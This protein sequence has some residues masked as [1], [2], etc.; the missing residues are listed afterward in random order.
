MKTVLYTAPTIYPVSLS[1]LKDH[2]RVDSGTFAG[3]IDTTQS[4]AP[5]SHVIAD[6]YTTHVGTGV[7]VSGYTA[8]VN[9]ESGTNGATGT[10]DVKIQE[11]DDNVT[12]TDWTGGAFTQVT[13]AN[14]NAIYE[15][16]YTGTKAY[17]RTVAKVLL[18]ACEFGTTVIRKNAQASDDTL[19]T[20]Y[21]YAAIEKAEVFTGRQL[22]TATWDAYLDQFPAEDYIELPFG[23]LQSIT[24]LKYKDSDGT[25]TTMTPTTDYLTETMGE[26][27]GR[28]VLAYG[29]S[30]PT[31]TAYPSNPITIRFICGWTAAASV[32]YS[33]KAAIQLIAADLYNNRET[34]SDR[35]LFHNRTAETLLYPYKLWSW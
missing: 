12:Y 30:W 10:V 19:L 28:I 11:S 24:S 18:A 26:R 4:I 22:L 5:G 23:N 29:K 33:I 7:S 16:E 20:A 1:E 9:L 15:K 13:T 17:I 27:K 21:L 6:N 25:E 14:D 34:I 32:P 31:F 3:N 35:E 8:I 2:L